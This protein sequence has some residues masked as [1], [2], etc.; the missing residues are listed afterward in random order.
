M[1]L[2]QYY[3]GS[4]LTDLV[5]EYTLLFELYDLLEQCDR[6]YWKRK[7]TEIINFDIKNMYPIHVLHGTPR[8]ETITDLIGSHEYQYLP[9][10]AMNFLIHPSTV[11]Q[12]VPLGAFSTFN[13][14]IPKGICSPLFGIRMKCIYN[15]TYK[16]FLVYFK[17][18]M[19]EDESFVSFVYLKDGRRVIRPANFML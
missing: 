19:N 6:K 4:D 14:M 11:L 9:V 3:L 8:Y 18:Y 15:T 7:L 17:Y 13:T 5:E 16:H 12:N 10:S 2:I 1:E